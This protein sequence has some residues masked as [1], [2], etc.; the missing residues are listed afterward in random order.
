MPCFRP[1]FWVAS[2]T[3]GWTFAC[4]LP[5]G[6]GTTAD[7]DQFAPDGGEEALGS[8]GH[9]PSD[10][11]GIWV[12][13]VRPADQRKFDVL[14]AGRDGERLD[15][16]DPPLQSGEEQWFTRV[17]DPLSPEY[18]WWHCAKHCRVEV[19][20]SGLWLDGFLIYDRLG[21]GLMNTR[22]EGRDVYYDL[23]DHHPSGR[24]GV[25]HLRMNKDWTGFRI[26]HIE[27]DRFSL[28]HIEDLMQLRY[29]RRTPSLR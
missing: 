14:Q 8:G 19:R 16:L 26:I 6:D 15:S 11:R 5:T 9:L 29:Y 2:L 21:S 12:A 17:I 24:E 4:G 28:A 10:L 27:L 1:Y 7:T 25:V 13:E 3:V 20:D 18:H 23:E 22:I